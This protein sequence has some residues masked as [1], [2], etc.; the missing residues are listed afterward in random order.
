M[1]LHMMMIGFMDLHTMARPPGSTTSSMNTSLASVHVFS[2][3]AQ[4]T[5]RNSKLDLVAYVCM[6]CQRA[7]DS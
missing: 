6:Y 5:A 3:A 2:M 1:I 4:E 7:G